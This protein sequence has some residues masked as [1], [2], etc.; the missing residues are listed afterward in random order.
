MNRPRIPGRRQGMPRSGDISFRHSRTDVVVV[1]GGVIGLSVAWRLAK[2]G[3]SVIV[4]DA[5][6]EGRSTRAAAG[7]LAPLAEA[8]TYSPFV[9][10]G[11]DSLA[12]YPSFLEELR[13]ASGADIGLCGPGMLRVALTVEQ[14]EEQHKALG[15]QARLG[16]PLHRL[17]G[18]EARQLEPG[19]GP[20]IVSAVLS[21]DEKHVP[22]RLLLAAL[23]AACART[24]V[25]L[26][27]GAE[28][29][30]YDTHGPHFVAIR[31]RN[32]ECFSCRFVVAATG[33]WGREW[34]TSTGRELPIRPLRGQALSLGPASPSPVAHTIYGPDGYTV[35]R[36]DGMV[37]VGA[38]EEDAGFDASTT[39][40]GLASL[41]RMGARLVPALK[42]MKTQETWA[43]LR[44][45]CSDGLPVL[46]QSP[47][48][49]N[50]FLALGHGRNGILLAPITA[51]L[52]ADAIVN[53]QPPPAA[54]LPTRFGL[55]DWDVP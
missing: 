4:M 32:Y 30:S 8:R 17:T 27:Q 42:G 39:R 53:N 23:R 35:P 52:I 2:R 1:G 36:L 41:R 11:R 34:R 9:H 37:V 38:T 24:T 10:L 31:T 13:D 49:D 16:L 14:A 40:E 3:L 19:L 20:D 12:L 5:G 55:P 44:P 54:F 33:A 47:A 45:V 26:K 18:D 15:W 22:P 28:T 51:E 48:I 46:G 50:V 29:M 21:P 25:T 6:R 43:G 7:M